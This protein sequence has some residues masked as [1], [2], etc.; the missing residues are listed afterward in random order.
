MLLILPSL[1]SRPSF[2]V[3]Q[4]NV[5]LHFTLI[6]FKAFFLSVQGQCQDALYPH[7][8]QAFFFSVPGQCQAALYPHCF[9]AY[10]L[11]VPGQCQDALYPHCF[12]SLLSQCPRSMSGCTLPSLFSKPSFSVSQVNV[13]LHFTLIVFKAFFLSVP[14][15]CQTALYPH[16]F[17][18]LLSQCPRSMSGCTL[19][20]LFFKP[21]FS[22]S[23]V[24]VR[25]HFTLIVFK[26]FFLS[27]PGQCQT[28]LY[29]HCFQAFFLSVQG[30]CQTARY[31]Q[32]F[33]GFLSQCCRSM[34][35]C[36]LP[37]LF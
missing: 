13:R 21:S 14:G 24:N 27:V 33:Q 32:C 22:V 36:T 35:D 30:Q 29:P 8:F 6:V 16:C 26:A 10:F 34:S 18:S 1:F 25:L 28:A 3:L 37:S 7:C 4:V 15:Q 12:Q 23:Q 17:Q 2:S 11:S 5:R 20:S 31:P 19:P 9:Q